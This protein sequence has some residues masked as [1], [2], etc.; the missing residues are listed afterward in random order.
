MQLT[1]NFV[2]AK[3]PCTSGYRWFLRD[4]Q[5]SGD[6]QA[7]LDALVADGRIDDACWLL[8]Q[9]GPTDTVLELDELDAHALVY[10]GTVRL[11]R[12]GL[13]DGMLR[14]G[15]DIVTAAG[16]RAGTLIAGGRIEA[17][18]SVIS[19]GAIRCGADLRAAWGVQAGTTLDCAGEVRAQW[20]VCAGTDMNVGAMLR[21]GDSVRAGGQLKVGHGIK[22]G[23]DVQSGSDLLVA[24]GIEAGG[25]IRAG[26]HLE[27]GW[28]MRAG[29]AVR[30]GMAIRAGEGIEAGH[31]IV[32][33]EGHGVY[34]GLRVRMDAWAVA[35][36][37]RAPRCAGPLVSGHWVGEP[38]AEMAAVGTR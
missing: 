5:G 4:Q 38:D 7:V 34:A 15:G 1:K 10:A 32:P 27:T 18:A 24:R 26:D 3:N 2:K 6:Y 16:L 22:A 29:G 11:R 31:D 28:G 12:G 37:V 36:R 17:R 30:A 35:A 25:D 20:E 19:A 14:A 8:D 33:G 13:A 21:T 23:G 9:F